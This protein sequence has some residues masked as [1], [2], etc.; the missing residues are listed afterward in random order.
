MPLVAFRAAKVRYPVFDGEG[1]RLAGGRWH[2]A[3]RPLIYAST[4]LAGALL[5]IVVH[6][7]VARL[8]GAHHAAMADIPDSVAREVLP[9]EGL[10]GWDAIPEAPVA[11]AYGDRWLAEARSAVLL[12]PATTA[13]PLQQHVLLNPLHPDYSRITILPAAPVEWDVRLFATP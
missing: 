9:A 6:L 10:P 3:G 4:C 1:A 8:P 5:E 2:S 11:R 13:R 7:G 12:V